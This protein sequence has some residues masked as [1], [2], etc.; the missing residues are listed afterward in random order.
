MASVGT[1]TWW[2]TLINF[3]SFERLSLMN[4]E[5]A[6]A[7]IRFG[8]SLSAPYS[9]VILDNNWALMIQPALQPWAIFPRHHSRTQ[10]C[11]FFSPKYSGIDIKNTFL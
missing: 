11:S 9:S 1:P 5:N 7:A 10:Q 3:V 6:V 8:S 4:P 2:E